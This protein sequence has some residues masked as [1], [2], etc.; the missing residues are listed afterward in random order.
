MDLA[1]K[2]NV[3]DSLTPLVNQKLMDD[4]F[5]VVPAI[6]DYQ[7]LVHNL[8]EH[9]E[10]FQG[11][12]SSLAK[13]DPEFKAYVSELMN[14]IYMPEGDP[15]AVSDTR[16]KMMDKLMDLATKP[17]VVDS[18][19]PLV[20]QKLIDDIFTLPNISPT[21]KNYHKLVKDLAE[22]E[23]KEKFKELFTKLTKENNEFKTYISDLMQYV[24][25]EKVVGE[26][27]QQTEN[28]TFDKS[29]L[30]LIDAIKPEAIESLI[31]LINDKLIENVIAL[32]QIQEALG[33]YEKEEKANKWTLETKIDVDNI[34]KDENLSKKFKEEFGDKTFD[35]LSK[36]QL[37]LEEKS[38]ISN[39]EKLK[40]KEGIEQ[41]SSEISPFTKKIIA[42]VKD[43]GKNKDS[44][45]RVCQATKD[46]KSSL[47]KALDALIK[48]PAG[49]TLDNF[50]LTGEQ[51]ADFLPKAIN[52][53]GLNAIASYVENPSTWNL[54]QIFAKT[55]TLAFATKHYIMSITPDSLKLL[56][57]NKNTEKEKSSTKV[58]ELLYKRSKVIQQEHSGR[59]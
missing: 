50:C 9:K 7:P 15:K 5:N 58:E 17:N 11:L 10:K 19:I 53:K 32:P 33:I 24:Y 14:F 2:P 25:P 8:A 42:M 41:E 12:F 3:V 22:G 52:E 54:I 56:L 16:N 43:L 51:V 39:S 45:E 47:T 1:T 46:N 30:S 26:T 36:G 40:A 48:S 23:N 55:N 29:M 6:K 21:V 38:K 18:L 57:Y 59:Q 35:D 28:R 4:V 13:Q 44:C 49:K 20:D 31:P 34:L 27:D 37:S